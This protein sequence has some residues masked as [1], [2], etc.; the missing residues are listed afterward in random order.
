M[1]MKE[2][3]S[4]STNRKIVCACVSSSRG[5]RTKQKLSWL[6]MMPIIVLLVGCSSAPPIAFLNNSHRQTH[7]LRLDDLRQIQFYLSNDVVAR[8][9][10]GSGTKSLLLPRLTPGVATSEGPNWIKVSFRDGGVDVP[11]ITDAKQSDGRYYIATEVTGSKEFKRIADLP[12]QSFLY[13]GVQYNV[14]SGADALLLFDWQSWNRVVETR[15]TTEGR[16][17]TDK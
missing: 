3:G 5:S 12:V 2:T 1:E 6:P 13:E 4:R 16:R 15:K 9:Q 11:F 14:V 8:Y 7:S 10:D 17:V